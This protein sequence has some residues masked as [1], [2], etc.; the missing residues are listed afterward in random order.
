MQ[1]AYIAAVTE[2]EENPAP[3]P[4]RENR[5]ANLLRLIDE[6]GSPTELALALETPKTHISAMTRT[7]PTARNVGDDLA[8]RAEKVFKKHAGWMDEAHG[9]EPAAPAV[10][11][12]P[13][14][15]ACLGQALAVDMPDDVRQDVAHL[16]GRL[17]ERR[18]LERHQ[19]DLVRLLTTYAVKDSPTTEARGSTAASGADLD[20]DHALS[21]PP[22]EH[23]PANPQ[24]LGGA[25]RRHP[26]PAESDS[27]GT[28]KWISNAPRTDQ[29]EERYPGSSN[30]R[31]AKSSKGGSK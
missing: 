21:H 9:G 6:A 14:A 11:E 27:E 16:L 25:G 23:E 17:A 19:H 10:I 29:Q 22:A 18:G 7:G 13:D 15:L 1:G 20:L 3:R 30:R 12:L 2:I 4:Y 24:V 28:P 8:T 26:A 5:R 31:S